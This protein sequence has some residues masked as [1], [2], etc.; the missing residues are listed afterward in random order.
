MVSEELI[1]ISILWEE[2]WHDGL[3]EA[4]R[5]FFGEHDMTGML[6]VLDPLHQMINRGSVS[7]TCTACLGL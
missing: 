2:M 5:L 1:R 6:S 7:F 4:S 3:E